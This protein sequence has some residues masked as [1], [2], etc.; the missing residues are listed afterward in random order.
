MSSKRK[1]E[2][3]VQT[4]KQEKNKAAVTGT[5]VALA[6]SMALSAPLPSGIVLKRRLTVPSLVMKTKGER[7]FLAIA[8][9]LRESK[10]PGK[11][12]KAPIK[13]EDG[14]VQTH[15]KPATICTVGDVETGEVFT[16][17]VPAVVKSTFVQEGEGDWYVGRCF[18]VENLGKREGKRHVDFAVAEVDPSGLRVS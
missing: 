18:M 8:D 13:L 6:V 11:Q 15:E 16:W 2:K 4:L 7:R 10:V 1:P 17:L 12:L 5:S 3:P 9:A 14:T